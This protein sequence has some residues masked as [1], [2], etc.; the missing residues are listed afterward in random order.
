VHEL[1]EFIHVDW[2]TKNKGREIND[3]TCRVI[4]LD[5]QSSIQFEWNGI[6]KF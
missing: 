4:L 6:A 1:R 5:I 3:S 2:R